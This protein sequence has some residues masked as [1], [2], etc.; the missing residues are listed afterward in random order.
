MIPIQEPTPECST[1]RAE[2]RVRERMTKLID[3]V[4]SAR[5]RPARACAILRAFDLI[6]G[7]GLSSPLLRRTGY[8]SVVVH[9]VSEI[10]D[11]VAELIA[12]HP[13]RSTIPSDGC[14]RLL[15]VCRLVL[16]RVGL[17]GF[18]LTRTDLGMLNR[19]ALPAVRAYKSLQYTAL[20]VCRDYFR[21]RQR[22]RVV[23]SHIKC[24]R[25]LEERCQDMVVAEPRQ[26]EAGHRCSVLWE[27]DY[28]P[29]KIVWTSKYGRTCRYVFAKCYI[30]W[31]ERCSGGC[32]WESEHHVAKMTEL[33]DYD[34]SRI[35]AVGFE[36]TS[37]WL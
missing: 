20:E 1:T 12:T 17:G 18:L 30:P 24:K 13:L 33:Y 5:G 21:H 8:M 29:A 10:V 15:E 19:V 27:G 4:G 16:R 31:T 22:M 14:A 23:G 28:R 37:S 32:S 25:S 26:R 3:D 34:L 7:G 9:K 11:D 2:Q 6:Q 36:P 35:A